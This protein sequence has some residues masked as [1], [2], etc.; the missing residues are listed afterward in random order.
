M[1]TSTVGKWFPFVCVSDRP[2][3][4]QQLPERGIQ[5]EPRSHDSHMVKHMTVTWL[6]AGYITVT[7]LNRSWTVVRQ[8][9]VLTLSVL[10][11]LSPASEGSCLYQRVQQ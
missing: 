3:S 9:E 2:H 5:V 4:L 1:L 6:N 11:D 7:W 8:M 10:C